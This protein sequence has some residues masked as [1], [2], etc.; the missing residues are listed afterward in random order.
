MKNTPIFERVSPRIGDRRR[1][2]LWPH[3]MGDEGY[4][5]AQTDPEIGYGKMHDTV[6]NQH[7]ARLGTAREVGL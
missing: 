7:Q 2:S 6:Q 3:Q 5:A 4:R 1:V